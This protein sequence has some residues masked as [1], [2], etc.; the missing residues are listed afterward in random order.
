MPSVPP[1][2]SIRRFNRFYTRKIGVL[3]RGLLDSPFSLTEVRVLYELA[4]RPRITA[5]ELGADLGLDAGYLSR[6][7]AR[8]G[9]LQLVGRERAAQDARRT[10][11]RL[12]AKGRKTFAALNARS[13]A[14][15]AGMIGHLPE[16]E[17]QRLAG[18]MRT[19][20]HLLT[21][22]GEPRPEVVLRAPQPGDLGWVVQRH[23]ALYSQEY[24]WDQTFEALVARIVA[25][26]GRNPDP[27][28]ERCWIAE[29]AGAPVGCIFLVRES[30]AVAK[31]RLL[32]VEP[33]A[34]GAG[35]GG[36]LVAECI[37][38]A[39]SAGYRKITLWTNSVLHAAR[40]IYEKAG[41]KLVKA[42]PHRS[43]GHELVGQYW[44]LP[45][46]PAK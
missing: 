35:V 37:S 10:H 2:D 29:M 42:E 39:R 3:Q 13:G 23:G 36:K 30:D 16:P 8:F 14:Q 4:H 5:T 20:E 40:R 17:Q 43:F 27:R 44:E 24:N 33:S 19:V 6:M 46:A 45:L 31:L 15:V 7:L 41:F 38:F 28:R 22:P 34:R 21:A 26:F 9:R 18:V 32:L 1:A 12:T 11:L 25:D